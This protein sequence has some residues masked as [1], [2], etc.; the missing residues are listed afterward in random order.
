VRRDLAG[1]G[2][3]VRLVL[4]RDRTRLL[5]WIGAIVLLVYV[6]AVS[7]I[8]IY[9]TQ[10]DL[11]L[12]AAAAEDN[13]VA[14]AFNGPDQALDTMGGQIAFQVGAFG[15]ALAGLMSVLLVGRA[16]R[17]EEDSGRLE[18]VRAMPVGRHAPL[19][20]SLLVVGGAQVVVAV[21]S[22]LS[23]VALD[24]ELHGSIV[25][26]GG[27]LAVGLLFLA[28]TAVTAQ[29]AE[30]PRVATGA[31][32]GVLGAAYVLRG[33]GDMSGGALSWLSPI[34]WA[35]K[36]RP[37]AGETWWPLGLALVVAIGLGVL[38][39][40]LAERRDFGGGMVAPRPGPASAGAALRSPF[41]LSLRLH[42]AAAAWWAAATALLG[43]VYG[44][45]AESVDDLIGDNEA[46]AD[47]IASL[48]GVSL[49]DSYLATSLLI[50]ALLAAGPALQIAGRLRAE[51]AELRAEPLLATPTSRTRWMGAHLVVA[52]GS[53]AVAVFVGGLGLGSGHAATGGGAGQVAELTVDGL[54]YLPALLVVAGVAVLLFGAAPR[55]TAGS[56]LVLAACFVIAMF[57]TLLDLPQWVVDLSPLQHVPPVPASDLRALPLVALTAV[58][59]ALVGAGLVAF[60]RR[61]VVAG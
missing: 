29:V 41:A 7:T 49:V 59:L 25:L 52:L 23:L 61:D 21:A 19:V 42:R 26:G 60:R 12:A 48:Q 3:L 14:L 34:G 16:T 57:G 39:I 55:W 27:F 20:A 58:A 24:Q 15:L 45:L 9:P 10:A 35:Q 43:F 33:A 36:A 2:A 53:T 44:S 31:A 5:V 22:A 28:L 13:P 50:T 47:L 54:S 8:E 17:A 37:F 46:M 11:D 4:R 1:T 56:W 32:G 18:L 51:E 38:A 40:S 30:N 6:S